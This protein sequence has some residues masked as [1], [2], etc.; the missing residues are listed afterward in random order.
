ME[1][2]RGQGLALGEQGRDNG[3]KQIP[4]NPPLFVLLS[5]HHFC[6]FR[7]CLY[8]LHLY[9]VC[10]YIYIYIYISV[11]VIDLRYD[12]IIIINYNYLSL[13]HQLLPIKITQILR[14]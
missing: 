13:K 3:I 5:L 9:I 11:V 7:A 12:N 8:L 1:G 10:V 14:Q 4:L 2:D 6:I